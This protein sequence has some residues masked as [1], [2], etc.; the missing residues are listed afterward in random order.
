MS[1]GASHK[2]TP[3]SSI[4]HHCGPKHAAG[5]GPEAHKPRFGRALI[6]IPAVAEQGVGARGEGGR[7]ANRSFPQ[8][9][10]RCRKGFEI[11]TGLSIIHCKK[12]R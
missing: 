10:L 11:K 6:S 9:L 12:I 2:Q 8:G 5:V 4:S 1:T 3:L 7:Q